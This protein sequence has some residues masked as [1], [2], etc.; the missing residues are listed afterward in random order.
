MYYFVIIKELFYPI[1]TL[2]T[3]SFASIPFSLSLKTPVI[4]DTVAS[5][6]SIANYIA[7]TAWDLTV[8]SKPLKIVFKGAWP[9]A[10]LPSEAEFNRP[11]PCFF[12]AIHLANRSENLTPKCSGISV[13]SIQSP[14]VP[15]LAIILSR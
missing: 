15:L 14:T 10:Y 1:L 12:K 8:S 5:T 4:E 6:A 11:I 13:S 9:D 7:Y 2:V 3:A